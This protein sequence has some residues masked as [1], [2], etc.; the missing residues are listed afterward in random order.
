MKGMSCSTN[1]IAFCERL[2]GSVDERRAVNVIYLDLSKAF[3][4]VSEL[5]PLDKLVK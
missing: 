5:H 2:A 1:L 3:D 4:T